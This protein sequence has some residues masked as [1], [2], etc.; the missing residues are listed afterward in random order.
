VPRGDTDGHRRRATFSR[1]AW[2]IHGLAGLKLGLVLA[3][4]LVTGTLAVFGHEWDW[5]LDERL[6]VH[7]EG[8]PAGLARIHDAIREAY[9][10]HALL[11]VEAPAGPRWAATALAV[12]PDR[13][14]RRITVDPYRPHRISDSGVL[15]VQV[16]LRQIHQRLL[17]PRHGRLFVSSLSLLTLVSLVSGLITYKRFWHGFLRRPRTRSLR[18]FLGDCHR[19][20]AVW[21]LWFIAIIAVT[22]LW[23]LYE[24]LDTYGEHFRSPPLP[25]SAVAEAARCDD[26]ECITASEAIAIATSTVPGLEPRHLVL[27][28]WGDEPLVVEGQGD[29]WLVRPRATAVAISPATGEVTQVRRASELGW[30]ARLHE[31]AD[32]LHFGTLG[33]FP[34]KLAWFLF[35]AALSFLS[36][37][38][39][40]IHARRL[41]GKPDRGAGEV[42]LP[43]REG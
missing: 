2:W 33:G 29:A 37:S 24:S 41:T 25:E 32:P 9:P 36:I 38:G 16:F 13:Q 34:T 5:L 39:L 22:S 4:I 42:R 27:P 35:G 23:Y 3:F 11:R 7:P 10:D 20:L 8:E 43:A 12:S 21:S 1:W 18:L 17:L 31:A 15:S 28:G 30:K 6:R 26:G 40:A 14:Y 19:L